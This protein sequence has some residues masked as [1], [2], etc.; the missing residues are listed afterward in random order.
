MKKPKF[1][2]NDI[3]VFNNAKWNRNRGSNEKSFTIKV[4]EVSDYPTL[5]GIVIKSENPARRVGNRPTGLDPDYFYRKPTY[6]RDAS[7]RFV[8]KRRAQALEYKKVIEKGDKEADAFL[9]QFSG[10]EA[11]KIFFNYFQTF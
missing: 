5:A 7:G 8:S 6:R 2:V 9:D 1:E 11:V 4:T 10:S 3:A